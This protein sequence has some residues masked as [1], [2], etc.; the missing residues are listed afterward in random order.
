MKRPARALEKGEKV[1]SAAATRK[2]NTVFLT[3][4]DAVFFIIPVKDYI[5]DSLCR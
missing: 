4:L 1:G 3:V 5:L 2:P